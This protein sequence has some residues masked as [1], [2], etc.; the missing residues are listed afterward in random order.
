MIQ[1]NQFLIDKKL[2][3]KMILQVHDE[4]LFEMVNTETTFLTKEIKNI[5]EKANLPDINLKVP[6]IVDEG[7]GNTWAEAH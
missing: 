5:M 1:I 4:L 7:S 6:L 2:K 3:S